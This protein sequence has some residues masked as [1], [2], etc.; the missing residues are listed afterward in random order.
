MAHIHELT[1]WPN[2]R[3]NS[4]QLAGHSLPCAT[5]KGG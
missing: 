4:E 2:L 5:G 3:W 1:D